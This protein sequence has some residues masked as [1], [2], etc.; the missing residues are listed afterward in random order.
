MSVAQAQRRGCFERADG[1]TL[2]LDEMG[3]LPAELQT[4]LLRSGTR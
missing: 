4:R 3:E 1:S 2:F